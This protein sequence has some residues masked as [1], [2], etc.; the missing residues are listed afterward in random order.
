MKRFGIS[1]LR[2]KLENH[3][4]KNCGYGSGREFMF[5][6]IGSLDPGDVVLDAGCGEGNLR[7]Q[8]PPTVHYIGLDRYTGEQK[9]NEYAH[10]D[11][12]PTILGDVQELPLNSASC[13]VVALMHVL[14][15]VSKPTQ[16]FVEVSRVLQPG[17]YLFADV[18]FLHEIHHAPHDNYRYTPYALTALAQTANLEIV[19]IRPS[20]GYFRA[21]SHILQEAP[22]IIRGKNLYSFFTL[23]TVAYPL[24]GLGWLINKLQYLLDMQD[25]TQ[26][27]TCGYHCIFKKTV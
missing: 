27:F 19:E 18:P 9:N 5:R 17:G 24:R 23:L 13:K 11:M 20:G 22:V 26:T 8:L 21:L 2:K 1:T 3:Y 16:V 15:H 4:L 6:L 14:E 25:T 12:R 10:W 7:R